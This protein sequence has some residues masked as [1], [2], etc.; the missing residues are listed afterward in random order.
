MWMSILW[1]VG[2]GLGETPSASPLE[3]AE[4]TARRAIS[5]AGVD[6]IQACHAITSQQELIAAV[7]LSQLSDPQQWASQQ[8]G[9]RFGPNGLELDWT[10]LAISAGRG[11]VASV[12]V[13][14]EAMERMSQLA[15]TN[16]C[17]QL[18]ELS[19]FSMRMPASWPK[20][21]SCFDPLLAP[22]L[23]GDLLTTLKA[24]CIC[25][26]PRNEALRSSTRRHLSV[27]PDLL[28][29]PEHRSALEELLT[30]EERSCSAATVPQGPESPAASQTTA[31]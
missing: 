24:S 28:V 26:N 23:S 1:T 11:S 3:R 18:A 17:I 5:R 20:V 16:E 14:V 27:A 19:A 2:C 12:L 30:R 22:K 10:Q 25:A 31:P 8:P 7:D 9:V 6:D 21:D 13:T 15:S 29:T 4:L